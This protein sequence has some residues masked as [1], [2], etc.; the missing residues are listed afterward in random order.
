MTEARHYECTIVTIIETAGVESL[1]VVSLVR[2]K[3]TS[4]IGISSG[5]TGGAQGEHR[6]Y[7]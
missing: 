5:D 6:C 4:R 7:T 2:R 1:Y 3:S